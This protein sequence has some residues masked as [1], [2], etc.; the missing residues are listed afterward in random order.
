M[1]MTYGFI[2]L[3][4]IGGSIARA[5]REQ[6]KDAVIYAYN[7]TKESI[8]QA[9]ADGV[10]N[11]GLELDD[12]LWSE[13][14]LLFL[15]AP[16]QVNT[17]ILDTL[18]PLLS[19]DCLITDVGSVKGSIHSYIEEKNLGSRFI[20][21]HP[22]AGSERVGY[23]NSKA[24]LLQNAYYILTPGEGVATEKID[25]YRDLVKTIGALPIILDYK[26]HDFATAAVSHL[27]H[28]IAASL[29][30]LVKDNDNEDGLM[31]MIAAGGFKDITRIASAS[32]TMWEQICMTNTENIQ[33]LLDKYIQA[34][35]KIQNTLTEK[36]SEEI[37]QFFDQARIYRD[38]LPNHS[39]GPIKKHFQLLV[40][41]ADEPGALASIATILALNAISIKNIGITHNREYEGGILRIEFYDQDNVDKAN[42]ILSAKGYATS[43][44]A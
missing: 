15:C 25:M 1:S 2:S 12:P 40:D 34:L 41:I 14:D 16:V 9:E 24:L 13:C 6:Y 21:G 10:I 29:V 28:V 36:N 7:R 18:L 30:S 43:E 27:P 42:Q 32:P 20:G 44:L 26:Q 37:Y 11:K 3:G 17:K 39:A 38:S 31:K 5:I 22:M 8:E 33:I 19:E 35:T 4:L 23:I